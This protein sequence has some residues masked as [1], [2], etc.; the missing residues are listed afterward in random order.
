MF[1]SWKF[2]M[3]IHQSEKRYILKFFLWLFNFVFICR[4][5]FCVESLHCSLGEKK[6][7]RGFGRGERNKKSWRKWL[8]GNNE[9]ERLPEKANLK[10]GKSPKSQEWRYILL[11]AKILTRVVRGLR[12]FCF[13]LW[14]LNIASVAILQ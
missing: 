2:I 10:A 9:L 3:V 5:L 7:N 6:D 14:M 13:L 8:C 11:H 12:C 4:V 1:F